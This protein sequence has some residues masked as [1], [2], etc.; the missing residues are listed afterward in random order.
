MIDARH[1]IR[2]NDIFFITIVATKN[3]VNYNKSTFV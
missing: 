2:N 1:T 3:I